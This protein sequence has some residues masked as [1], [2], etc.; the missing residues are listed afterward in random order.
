M[1]IEDLKEKLLHLKQ[2]A[3]DDETQQAAS[4]MLEALEIEAD[5]TEE[6]LQQYCREVAE[7]EQALLQTEAP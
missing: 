2:V 7:L 4:T 1:C 5:W 6:E 3:C